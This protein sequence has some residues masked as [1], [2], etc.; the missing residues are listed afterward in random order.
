MSSFRPERG[1]NFKLKF[2][3]EKEQFDIQVQSS[4]IPLYPIMKTLGVTDDQLKKAWGASI[5]R[6]NSKFD[7]PKYIR[8]FADKVFGEYKTKGKSEKELNDMVVNHFKKES[9]LNAEATKL[10]LG[11]PHK[12]ITSDA[13]LDAAGKILNIHKGF[14]EPDRKDEIF[15]KR[16]RGLDVTGAEYLE[17]AMPAIQRN[18]HQ[19]TSSGIGRDN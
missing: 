17:A 18:I 16:F 19:N 14:D 12:N 15:F 7:D 10:T 2:D 8:K 13:L 4:H 11:K 3:P 5:F 9:V 6:K 1:R